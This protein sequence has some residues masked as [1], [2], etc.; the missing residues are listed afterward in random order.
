M[1]ATNSSPP[2][3]Q[4]NVALVAT[5]IYIML[6]LLLALDVAATSTYCD[7]L[8]ERLNDMRAKHGPESDDKIT[9]L[10]TTLLR[11]VRLRFLLRSFICI[12]LRARPNRDCAHRTRN[13]AW[14]SR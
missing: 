10:E 7:L 8:V 11:L 1:D 9:W 2:G 6:P 5:A 13:K 14:A 3:T 12:R 4:R